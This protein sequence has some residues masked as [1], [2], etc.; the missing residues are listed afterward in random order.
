MQAVKEAKVQDFAILFLVLSWLHISNYIEKIIQTRRR[1]CTWSRYSL[2]KNT[3]WQDCFWK[4]TRLAYHCIFI[5]KNFR[6]GMPRTPQKGLWPSPTQDF[7]P[8]Q[9]IL[10]RTLMIPV[11]NLMSVRLIP[12]WSHPVFCTWW[13]FLS[14]LK[15]VPVSCKHG[16]ATRFVMKRTPGRLERVAHA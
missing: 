9:K 10:D 8:K 11:Q 1:Q 4:C 14:G 15:L 3:I 7:S 16:T 5:S 2:S 13:D 6:G 12:K